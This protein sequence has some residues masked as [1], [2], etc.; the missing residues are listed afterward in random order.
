[1]SPEPDDGA[2]QLVP[3]VDAGGG[4]NVDAPDPEDDVIYAVGAGL[5]WQPNRRLDLR[6]DFAP[7]LVDVTKPEE[8]DLQDLALYFELVMRFY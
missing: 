1:L 8:D 5:R 4:W 6:L 3:F 7:P 2:L